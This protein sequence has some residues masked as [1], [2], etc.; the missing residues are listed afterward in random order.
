[1][2]IFKNVQFQKPCRLYFGGF[3]GP[4]I[5]TEYI[6]LLMKYESIARKKLTHVGRFSIYSGLLE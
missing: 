5:V 3:I 2:D 4:Y 1:M 6:I